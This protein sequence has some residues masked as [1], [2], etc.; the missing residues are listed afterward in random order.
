MKDH[1][2]IA[3]L[4]LAA[5]VCAALPGCGS[6]GVAA[7]GS[8]FPAGS[9]PGKSAP[10]TAAAAAAESPAQAFGDAFKTVDK[11]PLNTD[12]S[13]A[14]WLAAASPA[15]ASPAQGASSAL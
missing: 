10:A 14:L 5:L 13:I 6:P 2:S 8:A 15:T 12:I 11:N 4:L 9:A 1:R 7:R 3:V